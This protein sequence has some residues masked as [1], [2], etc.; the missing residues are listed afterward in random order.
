MPTLT[1]LANRSDL[2]V[3]LLTDGP[4]RTDEIDSALIVTEPDLLLRAEADP[5]ALRT[6]L[7]I[8][9]FTEEE[10]S[11][12]PSDV[13]R[14][15]NRARPAGVLLA[16]GSHGDPSQWAESR[17]VEAL[18]RW[19]QGHA[20]PLLL[21]ASE[22]YRLWAEI[23]GI[24]REERRQ[25][26]DH[27]REIQREVTRP[28]GLKHLLRWLAR[29]VGGSVVWLDRS[30]THRHAFPTLP[31]DVI[32]QAAADIERVVSGEAGAAAADVEAGVVH[33]QAIGA[34][35]H[36]AALVVARPERFPP[37]V[38][39]L[40]GEASRLL[41][42]GWSI[43]EF[44]RR[45][46]DVDRA[47]TQVR[48]VVLHLLLVGR[49]EAAH[50]VAATMGPGLAEEIRVFVVE[51][52]AALRDQLVAECE[53]ASR[54]RAWIVR[55][56]VYSGHVIVLAPARE[57]AG[58]MEATLRACAGRGTDIHVGRS[59]TVPLRELACGYRQAFHALATARGSTGSYAVFSHRGDLAALVRP[60]GYAWAATLLQPLREYRPHRVQDP[61]SAELIATLR[62]WLDFHGG[63]VRQL[64]IH[65]NTLS[66][67][68][69]HIELLLGLSLDDLEAQS[70]LH[71]ALRVLDGPGGA[72]DETAFETIFGTADVRQWAAIQ[73]SPLRSR[74]RAAFLE[75]LRVWLGNNARLE[76][77]A[78]ALG[79]SAPGA[80]KRLTRIEEIL[81]RSLLDSPSARHD[82]WFAL[83]LS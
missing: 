49:L 24:V 34:G 1:T 33:I 14:R 15:L 26:T 82:L 17:E 36:K 37:P 60:S 52:P 27:L 64:K 7:L 29:R 50:R 68:L 53:R 66:A 65:R 40:I 67:R 28:D 62:A 54:S 77:T 35:R 71:L 42:L 45:E 6:T 3:R 79:I 46:G 61:D 81:G 47:E 78:S 51:G 8:L 56:P 4:G 11:A 5:E 74:D 58:V 2:G 69:Q 80:R 48:E 19:A 59:G 38:R 23:M 57:V 16:V 70:K 25:T 44:S 76:P 30:G 55:C 75:T 20:T 22:P 18:T 9:P 73:L 21:A 41:S 63:A 72:G 31:A 10:R 32:E 83:H 12:R 39:N 43:E 13:M